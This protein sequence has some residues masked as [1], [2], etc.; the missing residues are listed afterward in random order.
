MSVS[1]SSSC[2][3]AAVRT[4]FERDLPAAASFRGALASV[5]SVLVVVKRLLAG[6]GLLWAAHCSTLPSAWSLATHFSVFAACLA[7]AC[8][9]A[10]VSLAA[11]VA[12]LFALF[13]ASSLGP[14]WGR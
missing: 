11:V 10:G 1:A 7:A 9:T 5:G 4:V 13:S 8:L 2:K 6:V 14:C 12:S 3:A